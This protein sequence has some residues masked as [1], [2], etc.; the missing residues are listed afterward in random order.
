VIAYRSLRSYIGWLREEVVFRLM[1]GS[2]WFLLYLPML[3]D[4]WVSYPTPDGFSW[5]GC[6]VVDV[7]ADW[8]C[9]PVVWRMRGAAK[10][11]AFESDLDKIRKMRPLLRY[12]WFE[13]RGPWN[14]TYPEGDVFKID[15]EG[16]ESKLDISALSRYRL[17]FVPLHHH[18][19]TNPK[20]STM[21]LA[22]F[23]AAAG[24][25]EIHSKTEETVYRGF[26]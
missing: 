14:G 21:R 24:G 20:A 10:V 23:L 1:S 13:F 6:T 25:K 26:R 19:G 9:S 18:P 7:G 8:G 2:P 3:E 16:C 5:N 12:P 15:C 4:I 11:I 22:P 17:W